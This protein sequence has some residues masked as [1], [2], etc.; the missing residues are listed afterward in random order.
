MA[1]QI[2]TYQSVPKECVDLI[3]KG[4]EEMRSQAQIARLVAERFEISFETAR[5]R[6]RWIWKKF[7]D[8]DAPKDAKTRRGMVSRALLRLYREAAQ[9]TDLDRTIRTL[10]EAG[11]QSEQ[12]WRILSKWD[13]YKAAALALKALEQYTKLHGLAAP[14]QLEV[15][16]TTAK[17]LTPQE[18]RAR[19]AVLIAKFKG[20]TP[21]ETPSTEVH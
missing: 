14:E 11:V 12:L 19:T 1:K 3:L 16:D 13:P 2:D 5:G 15:K 8:D 21:V 6:V 7:C 10:Q 17:N 20:E 18:Q 9:D 4:I